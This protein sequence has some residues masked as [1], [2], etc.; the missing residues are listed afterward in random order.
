MQFEN[1]KY[2]NV[3]LAAQF[4]NMAEKFLPYAN[5]ETCIL[6]MDETSVIKHSCCTVACHGGYGAMIF[7]V[8]QF[9]ED[10]SNVIADYLGFS[11]NAY[12]LSCDALQDWAG[13][14]PLLWGNNHGEV[15]FSCVKAFGK[16]DW[17]DEASLSDVVEHYLTVA[18]RLLELPSKIVL[19]N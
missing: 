6:D 15:M 13:S 11:D 10:G 3:Q 9:Y 16:A 12:C 18:K 19:T 14:N 5:N 4:I 17:N 8:G 2:D 7:N 1:C